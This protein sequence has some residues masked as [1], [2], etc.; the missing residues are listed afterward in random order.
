MKISLM[1]K[2]QSSQTLC[3]NCEPRAVSVTSRITP[4]SGILIQSASPLTAIKCGLQWLC[5][6][7]NL[8]THLCW[9]FV[10]SLCSFLAK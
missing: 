3:F 4:Q 10:L 6:F 5:L 1:K 7:F 9:D 2:I 8:G